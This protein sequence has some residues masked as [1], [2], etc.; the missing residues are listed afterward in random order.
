[1]TLMIKN[2]K[3]TKRL[4]SGPGICMIVFFS[5]RFAW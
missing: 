3:V 5:V 2:D 1:M 4:Q